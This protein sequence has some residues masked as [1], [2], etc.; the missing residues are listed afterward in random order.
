MLCHLLH[1]LCY[2]VLCYIM[3]RH[4]LHVLCYVVLCYIMLRYVMLCYVT[5]HSVRERN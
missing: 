4:L 2:V 5:F 3:L 1:V